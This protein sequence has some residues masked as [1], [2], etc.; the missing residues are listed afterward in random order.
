VRAFVWGRIRMNKN[1]IIAC[2]IVAASVLPL[3]AQP[4]GHLIDKRLGECIEK[5][6]TTAGMNNCTD[7]ACKQ[8][9][10]ELNKYYKLLMGVLSKEQKQQLK[11]SQIAWLKYR[12]LETKFRTDILLSRQ[13][14]IYSNLAVSEAMDIV[15]QRALELKSLY[16]T[17]KVMDE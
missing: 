12:D 2:A 4:S 13:G 5:N 11:D 17:L 14:T 10:A 16:D 3:F 9:D 8:W 1:I 7:E 15:K 6:S